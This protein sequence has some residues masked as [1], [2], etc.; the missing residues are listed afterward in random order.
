MSAGRPAPLE[1][2]GVAL[3]VGSAALSALI[4]AL[5]VPLY[6]GRVVFPIAVVLAVGGNIALPRMARQLVPTTFATVLPLLAWLAVMVGFGVYS[7]PEGDVILP[8]GPTGAEW[9]TY[10]VLLGGAV[11]GTFTV[12]MT[13][14]PPAQRKPGPGAAT[15]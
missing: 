12:V 3:V 4:E 10:G 8:G 14:P 11:A 1:I 5:L 2:A 9:V 6:A 13:M 7:R 15:R